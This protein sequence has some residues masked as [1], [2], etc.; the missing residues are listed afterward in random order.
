MLPDLR[1]VKESKEKKTSA[2]AA[3]HCTSCNST[4]ARPLPMP[5][6]LLHLPGNSEAFLLL[7]YRHLSRRLLLELL[8]D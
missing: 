1:Q 8:L 7:H 4:T 2:I 3:H 5:T 6:T